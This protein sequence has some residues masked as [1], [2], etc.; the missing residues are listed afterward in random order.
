MEEAPADSRSAMKWASNSA[1]WAK[2]RHIDVQAHQ[3]REWIQ[4][5]ILRVEHC[6]T[7]AMLADALTKALPVATHRRLKMHLLGE[8]YKFHEEY[9]PRDA[10]AAV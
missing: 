5:G 6:P 4:D 8:A 7:S 2:T 10:S 9:N 1:S 3:I